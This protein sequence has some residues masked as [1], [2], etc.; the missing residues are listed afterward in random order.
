MVVST[1]NRYFKIN[2]LFSREF[3]YGYGILKKL[4]LRSEYEKL[5]SY[6]LMAKEKIDQLGNELKLMKDTLAGF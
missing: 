5:Q 3:W 6:Y 1:R 2:R 4:Y